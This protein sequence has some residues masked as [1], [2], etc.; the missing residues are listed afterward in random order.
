MAAPG[1]NDISVAEVLRSLLAATNPNASD[2]DLDELENGALRRVKTLQEDGFNWHISEAP[3]EWV[4]SAQD[5]HGLEGLPHARVDR[6]ARQSFPIAGIRPRGLTLA[7]LRTGIA[8]SVATC[9]ALAALLV[10]ISAPTFAPPWTT[11]VILFALLLVTFTYLRW[12]SIYSDRRRTNTAN[13]YRTKDR[14]DG[15]FTRSA[16]PA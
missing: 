9:L 13:D 1:D 5:L 3:S 4:G 14:S 7:S 6:K 16:S 12:R 11:N 15:F 2:R 10:L 8:L